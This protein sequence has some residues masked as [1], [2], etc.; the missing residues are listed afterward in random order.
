MILSLGSFIY[1][2]GQLQNVDGNYLEIGVYEGDAL[3]FLA[4][5]FP[6]KTFY[7]VD[8]F[9]SDPDT[10][11][12]HGVPVGER[13]ELQRVI[14]HENFF[15]IENIIFFEQTSASFAADMTDA[16][17]EAMNIS[18]IY[19]DGRHTYSDTLNDL[20][21]GARCLKHGG[22]IYVDDHTIE[23]VEAMN[24]FRSD[25]KDRIVQLETGQITLKCSPKN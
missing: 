19:V 12:H 25:Y 4:R 8:P 22:L 10:I 21:L 17:L 13:L 18:I 11:G 2:C 14:A 5:Q 20:I 7:G 3:R 23:T 6:L 1:L 24:K 15:G 16:E 9:I